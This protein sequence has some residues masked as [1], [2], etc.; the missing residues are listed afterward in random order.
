MMHRL[1]LSVLTVVFFGNC[2]IAMAEDLPAQGSDMQRKID[3][4][5]QVD[6]EL[7]EA[8]KQLKATPTAQERRRIQDRI[9]E[10]QSKQEQLL[11]ELE[12]AVGPPA[13]SVRSEPEVPLERQMKSRQQRHETTLESDVGQRLKR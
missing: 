13:P 8:T 11:K 2:A 1:F 4:V 9:Q 12:Q 7:A 3:E 6:R 5:E 10:L